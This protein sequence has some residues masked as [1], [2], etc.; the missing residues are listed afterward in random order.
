MYPENERTALLKDDWLGYQ[1]D[2]IGAYEFYERYLRVSDKINGTNFA[3]HFIRR[4]KNWGPS[5]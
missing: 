5:A 2:R 1:F 3:N 4:L